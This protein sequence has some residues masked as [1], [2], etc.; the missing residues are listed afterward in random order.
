[1][2][3][4]EVVVIL[5]TAVAAA[6]LVWRIIDAYRYAPGE[7]IRK[8]LVRESERISEGLGGAEGIKHYL[9][10]EKR[11]DDLVETLRAKGLIEPGEEEE[12]REAFRAIFEEEFRREQGI[13]P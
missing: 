12:E 11:A 1:M 9:F 7:R 13:E 10:V 8:V 4:V 5:I 2:E 6:V 3:I